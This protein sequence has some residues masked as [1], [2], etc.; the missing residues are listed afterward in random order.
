MT[1]LPIRLRLTC[2]YFAMFASAATLLCLTSLWM[3]QRSVDETEYHEMQERVDDVR[4]VLGHEGADR[5]LQQLSSDLAAVYNLKDDGKYLQVRDEEGNWVFRSRRMIEENLELASPAGLP[6]SGS[7]VDFHQGVHHVRTL[8]FP[9]VARGQSYSVQTGITMDKSMALLANFR[10]NLLLLTPM[11]ILLAAVGGHAMS[12][13]ALR[14]VA[15]LSAEV[16]RINDRNLDTRLPISGAKDEISDLCRTLNQMLE[17]IDKAFASVRAFT[18][19]AS[20]ELRTPITL[21]RTEIEVAL[22]RPRR[23][24]EYRATLRRLHEET[25]RITN[26]V[27]NLL[28]LARADGGA[29]TISI[30]PI[31]VSLLL[32]QVAEMW[33]STMNKS[34]LEFT[35]E[36]PDDRLVVLGDEHGVQRVLSIL[37]EN[38]AKFTPPGGVVR[39]YTTDDEAQVIFCVQDTGFGI[40]PEHKLR[41][42]DRFYRAAPNG[43]SSGEGSGLGL[44]L[45]KWIIE[46][47]GTGLSVESEPGCGSCF[48]FKLEKFNSIRPTPNSLTSLWT[49]SERNGK[50]SRGNAPPSRLQ[51]G[52]SSETSL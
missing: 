10:T 22:Y 28:S 17:R 44:A 32:H 40:A 2:W 47:H 51:K 39:L 30:G 6:M 48:S 37:L 5:N 13:K 46:R 14:P 4:A 27:E 7:I 3:L 11:M 43:G 29:E 50:V 18:G 35:A 8:A 45:A 36:I 19:N 33:E 23:A 31:Q 1:S 52:E 42:F 25:V 24:D 12:R 21:L 9:I 16:Q 34:M 26:L 15:E 38:A 49:D 20:H 41:I